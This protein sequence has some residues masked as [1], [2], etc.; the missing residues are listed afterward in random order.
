MTR[1]EIENKIKADA[2]HLASEL[3]GGNDTVSDDE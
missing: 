2:G 3:I 1:E